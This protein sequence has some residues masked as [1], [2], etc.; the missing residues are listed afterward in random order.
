MLSMVTLVV[1]GEIQTIQSYEKHPTD[2]TG[3]TRILKVT[4]IRKGLLL[5]RE[6]VQVN[7]YFNAKK[8]V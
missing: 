2:F 8:Q 6:T 7:V 3:R 1:V 5:I 4:C